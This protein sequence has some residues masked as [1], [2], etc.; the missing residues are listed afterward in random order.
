MLRFNSMLTTS[1]NFTFNDIDIDIDIFLFYH[2]FFIFS[3]TQFFL[4]FYLFFYT[5]FLFFFHLWEGGAKPSMGKKRG[6][7]PRDNWLLSPG[8]QNR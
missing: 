3:R 4:F 8:A 5:F 6:A 2:F 7:T 1:L